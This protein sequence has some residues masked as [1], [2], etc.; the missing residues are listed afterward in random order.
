MQPRIRAR[1]KDGTS[2]S[3]ESRNNVAPLSELLGL[4]AQLPRSAP[5]YAN[6]V[7]A[8][9]QTHG[10]HQCILQRDCNHRHR[11][12][13][14]HADGNLSVDS[15]ARRPVHF[16]VNT[17]WTNSAS[18]APSKGKSS[19]TSGKTLKLK[20]RTA[21]H[22]IATAQLYLEACGDAKVH[23]KTCASQGLKTA[24]TLVPTSR[25]LSS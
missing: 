24:R 8:L 15:F 6:Q 12:K 14:R 20:L 18:R 10:V 21:L 23:I 17:V 5:G 11:P 4:A 13:T 7:R 2:S 25:G 9:A 16:V 3:P 1:H 22:A 19:K